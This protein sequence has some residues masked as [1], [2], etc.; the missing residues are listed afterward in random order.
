MTIFRLN[1]LHDGFQIIEA[2]EYLLDCFYMMAKNTA[3]GLF[4]RLNIFLIYYFV[5]GFYLFPFVSL[6]IFILDQ[7]TVK[8]SEMWFWVI[9][10]VSLAPC[11]L[12]GLVLSAIGLYKSF[13]RKS[14]INKIIGFAGVFLGIAGITGGVLGFML[15]YMV[16]K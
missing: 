16:L 6:F 7:L 1:F 15:L 10:L 12:T 5:L 8:R 13:R 2:K 11:G 9:F 4:K 3:A 14:N